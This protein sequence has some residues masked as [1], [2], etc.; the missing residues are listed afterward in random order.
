MAKARTGTMRQRKPGVWQLIASIE[1]KQ[2]LI[3]NLTKM[4]R[5]AQRI[6]ERRERKYETFHGTEAGAQARLA[7]MQAESDGADESPSKDTVAG[8]MADWMRSE[9]YRWKDGTRVRYRGLVSQHIVPFLGDR[10]VVSLK[11]R[12]I[13]VFYTTLREHGRSESTIAL[14]HSLLTTVFAYGIDVHELEMPKN[15]CGRVKLARA[16][17]AEIKIPSKLQIQDMLALAEEEAHPLALAVH[18]A[19]YTGMR[20]GEIAGLTWNHVN[21]ATGVLK[22][23]Q[24]LGY[25]DGVAIGTPKSETSNRDIDLD[26]AT[27]GA[28]QAHRVAQDAHRESCSKYDD[29]AWVFANHKG[30]SFHPGTFTDLV[31]SL[32]RRTGRHVKFH[33][34]RHFHA[35]QMIHAG[36]DIV[37][38]SKRL[39]HASIK[40]TLDVYGHLVDGSQK[41]AA[42]IFAAAMNGV[43][44]V[45]M[46]PAKAKEM[47]LQA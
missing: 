13:Q 16:K 1:K 19:V 43:T 3:D 27:V 34:L 14:I 28:L 21:L 23:R 29:Q 26:A 22:V 2:R 6:E 8:L 18:L 30:H 20:R 44:M 35:T 41:R 4:D 7:A 38:V 31:A 11:A 33:D 45:P 24:T 32:A 25:A 12:D 47:V 40:M 37:T 17:K 39:G 36:V 42:D 5:L 15:P 10:V 9:S 46:V